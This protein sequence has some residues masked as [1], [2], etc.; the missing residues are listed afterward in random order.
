[1]EQLTPED[2]RR[3]REK[4]LAQMTPELRRLFEGRPASPG[5]SG[6]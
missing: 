2:R 5:L 6:G 4:A 1:M 3:A